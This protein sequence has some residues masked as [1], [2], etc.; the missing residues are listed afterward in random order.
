MVDAGYGNKHSYLAPHK[1]TQYHLNEFNGRI[2]VNANELFNLRHSSFRNAIERSF[3]ILKKQF[4]ILD[5][6]PHCSF[7]M[8]V[9][10]VMASCIIHNLIMGVDPHDS[11]TSE[12]LTEMNHNTSASQPKSS[13]R[14]QRD[15]SNR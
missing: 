5:S 14:E 10:I 1:G 6:T 12:A 13:Q 15:E 2:P 4:P 8:Q 3:G 7:P 11:I 9:N